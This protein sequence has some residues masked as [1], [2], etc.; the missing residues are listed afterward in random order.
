[1]AHQHHVRHE[2]LDDEHRADAADETRRHTEAHDGQQCADERD[3]GESQLTRLAPRVPFAC[4]E[5][6]GDAGRKQRKL[7]LAEEREGVLYAPYVRQQHH[8]YSL[9]EAIWGRLGPRPS[10]RWSHARRLLLVQWYGCDGGQATR[11]WRSGYDGIA[12]RCIATRSGPSNRRAA[13]RRS[14]VRMGRAASRARRP[15]IYQSRDLG[16]EV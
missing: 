16:P 9:H 8:R 6:Q 14:T 3:Q 2:A 12:P 11:S 10:T 15:P 13:W 7:D 4:V 1:Q 5:E